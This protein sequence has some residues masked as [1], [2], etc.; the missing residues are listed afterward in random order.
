M[1]EVS[2]ET[3]IPL[4]TL[5]YMRNSDWGDGVVEKIAKI[6]RALKR[7]DTPPAS[8]KRNSRKGRAAATA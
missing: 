5:S 6:D 1:T 3:G 7:I 2:R 4:T 8:S